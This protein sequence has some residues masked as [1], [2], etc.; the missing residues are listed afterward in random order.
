MRRIFVGSGVI[1]LA[2]LTLLRL[3]DPSG[4]QSVR[5]GYFD[6]LQRLSPREAPEAPVRIVDIDEASLASQGQWPWPRDKLARLVAQLAENGASAIVFD[7]IFPEPD[8]FSSWSDAEPTPFSNDDPDRPAAPDIAE[9]NDQKFANAIEGRPVVLGVADNPTRTATPEHTPKTGFLEFGDSPLLGLP[10][11]S[12]LVGNLPVL[13]EAA[14]GL[15]SINMSP[16]DTS[17]VVRRVPVGWRHDSRLL[18]SLAVEAVRVAKGEDTISLRGESR[19]SGKPTAL[20]VGDIDIPVMPDGSFPLHYRPDDPDLYLSAEEFLVDEGPDRRARI[21]GHVVLIGTSASGLLDIRA[22]ALGENV[23]GVSIHAQM[24]EQM[25]SGHFIKR[26]DHIEAL[27]ILVFLASGAALILMM[28]FTGPLVTIGTGGA[29]GFAVSAFSLGIFRLD[30][31]LFDAS[32]IVLGGAVLFMG[33]TALQFVILDREK[34][35]LRRSFSHYVA[36]ELLRRIEQAGHHVELGGEV[37]DISVMFCDI[38]NFTALSEKLHPTD[39]VSLLNDVFSDFSHE[40]LVRSG[41]IDKYIGDSIMAFWNAPLDVADHEQCACEAALAIRQRLERLN[42]DLYERIGSRL[43]IA[44]GISS[45]PACVGNIGS[46]ERFNY[47]A[48]GSVVNEAARIEVAC[49][50]VGCDILVSK[51]TLDGASELAALHAGKLHLRGASQPVA[52]SF[53]I[54]DGSV[55]HSGEF[56]ALKAFHDEKVVRAVEGAS[57]SEDSRGIEED[58]GRKFSVE[59]SGFFR[60]MQERREDYLRK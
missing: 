22:T 10:V 19:S 50:V 48:I 15:G 6:Q 12:G 59:L 9:T 4:L 3:L 20:S 21:D 58:L 35:M 53:L 36:P 45:G 56:E 24:I 47:S 42:E 40:I 8:R 14:A 39:M 26:G 44:V 13:T 7:M 30:G 2:L 37:R 60:R 28:L 27:E 46:R 25:L 5:D 18:P 31:I 55:A 54:G 11:S 49:R 17:D 41:T 38:R 51:R 29:L 32:F 34:R 16:H 1:L 33:L 57:A 23:P 43:E 52:V